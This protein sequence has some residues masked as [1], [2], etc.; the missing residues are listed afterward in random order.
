MPSAQTFHARIIC[1]RCQVGIAEEHLGT[2]GALEPEMGVVVPGEAD[3]AVDL[4]RVDRGLHI[5]IRGARLGQRGQRRQVGIVLGRRRGRG[6]GGGLGQL[7]IDQHVGLLVLHRLERGDRRGRT[8]RAGWRSRAPT[9]AASRRRRPSRSPGTARPASWCAR[10]AR[11]RRRP[12]R[13]VR[14]PR[15][16]T[17]AAPACASGPAPSAR[18]ASARAHRRGTVKNDR[19]LSPSFRARAS[20]TIRSA[21]WPSSTKLF[22]PSSR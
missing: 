2:L 5:G 13:A 4:D 19:P 15:R 9:G 17:P 21:V 11:R 8:A 22:T 18:G 12:R 20:T 6:I 1:S 10:T 14:P 3:A 7:D 16:G